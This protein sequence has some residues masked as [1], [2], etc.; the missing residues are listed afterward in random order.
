MKKEMLVK[1]RFKS[2]CEFV[3]T[4]QDK[5]KTTPGKILIATTLNCLL[6]L[7]GLCNTEVATSFVCRKARRRA[8]QNRVQNTNRGDGRAFANRELLMGIRQ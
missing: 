8:M 7:P 2:S 3:S 5:K 1:S 4:L 6:Q